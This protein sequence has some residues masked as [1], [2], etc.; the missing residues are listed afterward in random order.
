MN[1]ESTSDE[2]PTVCWCCGEE[3]SEPELA[4][5]E[6]H[7]E[8]ALCDV[9]LGWLGDRQALRRGSRLRRAIPI[10][11]T[12]DVTRA[13]GHYAA[14]GFETEAWDGGG[15]GFASRDGVELHLSEIEGHVPATNVVSCYLFVGDA[16]ALHSEWVEARAGG[17]LEVP[18]DTDYGLREGRHVDPDG[19]VIRYGSPQ[20]DADSTPED[21]G[22]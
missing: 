4:R 21:E 22:S 16:D 8:V 18:S 14:L 2:S 9:C 11:A 5:L 10:L 6:C 15:Y 20:P 1:T 12:A 13:L 7:S 19:N 3:R 17:Q